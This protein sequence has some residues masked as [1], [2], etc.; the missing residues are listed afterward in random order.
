MNMRRITSLT[1][2]VSFVMVIVTSV[3]LYVTPH[4]RVAYWSNWKLMGLSKTQWTD[5]HINLGLLFLLALLL[6]IWYNWRPIVNYLK[7]KARNFRFFTPEMNIAL[8]LAVLF[9][10][11]TL[12]GIP[13]FS[14]VLDISEGIKERAARIYGE[15]PYGHAELSSVDVFAKKM[16]WDSDQTLEAMR[17]AGLEVQNT[18]QTLLDVALAN[19]LSPQQVFL[20]TK[21]ELAPEP[22]AAAGALPSVPPAGFGQ[23][24]LEA[25]AA[26]YGVSLQAMLDALKQQ[27]V[28]AAPDRSLKTIAED[29]DKSP[30][31][32]F[33]IIKAAPQPVPDGRETSQG[34]G[35]NEGA[36]AHDGEQPMGLGRMRLEE[37]VETYGLERGHVAQTLR[38]MGIEPAP[39][40]TMKS[41]AESAGLTPLDLFEAIK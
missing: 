5:I 2:L 32:L 40:A 35:L 20:K 26:E 22:S 10:A 24:S 14:T 33:E 30:Y 18:R 13:P 6:H 34:K 11:G 9:T 8:L 31:D 41:L 23:R 1:A 37:V 25:I 4:G 16:G 19:G 17:T 3:V 27:G 21:A 29:H 39:E 28:E 15:P 7:N 38:G 12:A 36:A